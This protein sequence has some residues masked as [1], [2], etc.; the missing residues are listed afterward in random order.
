[1]LAESVNKGTLAHGPRAGG[2]ESFPHWQRGQGPSPWLTRPLGWGCYALSGCQNTLPSNVS[3][4]YKRAYPLRGRRLQ[5]PRGGRSWPTS[6][7]HAT[8]DGASCA[9]GGRSSTQADRRLH[10]FA[11]GGGAMPVCRGGRGSPRPTPDYQGVRPPVLRAARPRIR[12]SRRTPTSPRTGTCCS[13]RSRRPR[14]PRPTGA[15]STTGTRPRRAR[16]TSSGPRTRRTSV[17]PCST[18]P[19]TAARSGCVTSWSPRSTGTG[20]S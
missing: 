5:D 13:G 17:R 11:S 4:T 3:L 1:L 14:R 9:A 15:P 20:C 18:R 6:R 12:W 10:R 19:T 8:P 16:P 2:C 7:R